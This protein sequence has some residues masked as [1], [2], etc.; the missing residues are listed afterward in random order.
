MKIHRDGMDA[1]GMGWATV[2]LGHV[3]GA[4]HDDAVALAC[5][6]ESLA[7]FRQVND[8]SGMARAFNA[9]GENMRSAGDYARAA[10]FYEEALANDRESGNRSGAAM[11]LHNL[12]Y[13]DLHHG[14]INDAAARFEESL[15]IHQELGDAVGVAQS[16]EGL[17]ATAAAAGRAK[18]AA[19]LFGT[20]DALRQAAGTWIDVADLPEH[21]RFLE[22]AKGRL[23]R[24]VFETTYRAGSLL[25]IDEALTRTRRDLPSPNAPRLSAREQQVIVLVAAGRTNR[26]IAQQ[27]GL[28]EAAVDTHVSNILRK[29]GLDSRQRLAN[30]L[31]GFSN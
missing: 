4:Q 6:E 25:S 7:L 18:L 28:A 24:R 12:G 15:L 19:L 21:E 27:L 13:V 30:Q 26:E 22:I 11:R 2:F 8:R 16:I 9:L 23:G 5:V 20:A 14:S 31:T 1:G 29:F 3:A 17:A 10:E